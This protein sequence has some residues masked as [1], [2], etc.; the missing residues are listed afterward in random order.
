MWTSGSAAYSIY[1]IERKNI[2]E[3]A[4]AYICADTETAPRLLRR[5][6][7][8]VYELG[9]VPICPKL[10]EAQY[11]LPDNADEKRDFHSIAHQKLGRCRMLVVCGNKISHSMSAEIGAAE[12][13]NIICTTLDGL[14]KI[15]EADE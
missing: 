15:K 8:K 13:R 3:K 5:Y 6:C 9:Y 14:I 1:R 7:R 4:F 12:K 2:M 10:S 11:L